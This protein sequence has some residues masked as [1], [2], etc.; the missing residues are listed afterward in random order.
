MSDKKSIIIQNSDDYFSEM[1]NE[2]IVERKLN[3]HKS[4]RTYLAGVLQYYIFSENFHEKT[5]ENLHVPTTLAELLLFAQNYDEPIKSQYLKKLGDRALY[6]SGF[7]SDYLNRRVVDVNYYIGMGEIA[8]DAL[9]QATREQIQSRVYKNISANFNLYVD[10]YSY[11]SYK[12]RVNNNQNIL[13]IYNR[14]LK[15]GSEVSKKILIDSG[16]LDLNRQKTKVG[17]Q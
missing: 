12:A 6:I 14:Y 9:S 5:T 13:E 17:R 2:A 15:T 10:V 11:I 3:I 1:V 7:F 4:V 8:F 16:I